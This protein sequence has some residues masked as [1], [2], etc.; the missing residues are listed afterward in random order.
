[1]FPGGDPL[2][3]V[4][5]ASKLGKVPKPDISQMVPYSADLISMPTNIPFGE[6]LP[7]ILSQFILSLPSGSAY[8]GLNCITL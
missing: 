1:M 8:Q 6:N 3:P 4:R 5:Y 7:D 2:N